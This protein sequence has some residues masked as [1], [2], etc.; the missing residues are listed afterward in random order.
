M[1]NSHFYSS[2]KKI[3]EI[4]FKFRFGLKIWLMTKEVQ[5]K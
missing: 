5:G 1:T 4:I 3:N 2:N